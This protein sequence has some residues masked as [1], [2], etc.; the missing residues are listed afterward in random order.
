MWALVL[1]PSLAQAWGTGAT[2]PMWAS[3]SPSVRQSDSAAFP[4]LGSVGTS[5]SLRTQGVRARDLLV[6]MNVGRKRMAKVCGP[7]GS[8]SFVSRTKVRVVTTE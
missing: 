2:A 8:E 1:A 3:A 5:P 6:S 4:K 7:R